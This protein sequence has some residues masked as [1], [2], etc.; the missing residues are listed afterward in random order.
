LLFTPCFRF[1]LF[2]STFQLLFWICILFYIAILIPLVTIVI[3]FLF[4]CQSCMEILLQLIFC[5]DHISRF[6]TLVATCHITINFLCWM[7]M[8]HLDSWIPILFLFLLLSRCEMDLGLCN[9]FLCFCST[10]FFLVFWFM[11][12]VWHLVSL[13]F[14]IVLSSNFLT[15]IMIHHQ[16]VVSIIEHTPHILLLLSIIKLVIL[17]FGVNSR[18][19]NLTSTTLIMLPFHKCFL[20]AKFHH[21]SS[22]MFWIKP[23]FFLQNLNGHVLESNEISS[24][25]PNC[26]SSSNNNTP[27]LIDPM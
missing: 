4:L 1:S 13:A 16:I 14:T 17:E 22:K 3:H 11:F 18:M 8:S 6:S 21:K 15:I 5:V 19:W 12:Y 24:F 20:V 7:G 10:I 23:Q 27:T 2:Y 9:F 26:I 25:Q